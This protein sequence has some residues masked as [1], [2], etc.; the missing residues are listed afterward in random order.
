[1]EAIK[2][3]GL[4]KKYKDVVAVDNLSLCVQQGELFSLL[5]VNGAGKT[6]LLKL[7]TRLYDPTEGEILYNGV[8]IKEYDLDNKLN[9]KNIIIPGYV[10]VIAAKL[11]DESGW[12]VIV[13]PKEASGIS[14]FAKENFA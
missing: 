11:K 7:L 6:T 3:E 10:A 9:H 2:I 1:M 8:N 14:G 12:N 4:T 13:G 5:G